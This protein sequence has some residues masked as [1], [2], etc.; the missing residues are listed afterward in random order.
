MIKITFLSPDRYLASAGANKLLSDY[1]DYSFQTRY[2]AT[3]QATG[4][5]SKQ[6]ADIKAQMQSDQ[7]RAAKLQRE[8][9]IYGVGQDKHNTTLSHLEAL[10][11]A[12]TTALAT[13]I[14]K[15]AAYRAMQAGDPEVSRRARAIA[16]AWEWRTVARHLRMNSLPYRRCVE[17]SRSRKR[18]VAQLMEKYGARNPQVIE[19]NQPA[20]ICRKHRSKR[21]L[22]DLANARKATWT[23]RLAPRAWLGRCFRSRRS[24]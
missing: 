6:L 12:L 22:G 17:K 10:D 9:E 23:L 14:V 15:E 24:G 7:A 11:S 1:I 2:L 5:L 16:Q 8:A 18:S 13:R 20:A 19:A 4:W 21:S 3:S